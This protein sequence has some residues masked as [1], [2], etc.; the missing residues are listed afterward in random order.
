LREF[1]RSFNGKLIVQL[2]IVEDN[3]P[4]VHR[5]ATI[6]GDLLP[7]ELQVSLRFPWWIACS[8]SAELER[9]CSSSAGLAATGFHDDSPSWEQ[10]VDA[11]ELHRSGR[12]NAEV[13][14]TAVMQHVPRSA[15]L[16]EHKVSETEKED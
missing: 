9:I 11:G 14:L 6:A 16:Q 13:M 7:D 3:K 8:A 2:T 10:I 4:Y 15:P 5:M 12:C 1:R